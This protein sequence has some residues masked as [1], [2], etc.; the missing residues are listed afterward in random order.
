MLDQDPETS[1]A[2]AA[3]MHAPLKAAL[4]ASLART[5]LQIAALERMVRALKAE[6]AAQLS[7]FGPADLDRESE[8]PT[9]LS[10]LLAA[11]AP[12]PPAAVAPY[13]PVAPGVW[14]GIDPEAGGATVAATLR[15]A[16]VALP[17]AGMARVARLSANPTFPLVE[18]PRWVTLETAVDVG[19]LATAR[20]LVVDLVACLEIGS[21]NRAEIPPHVSAT[22]RIERHDGTTEDFVD[23]RVPVSSMPMEHRVHVPPAQLAAMAPAEAAAATLIFV[24]PLFGVYTFHLDYLSV[25]AVTD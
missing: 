12:F 11:G 10:T 20:E 16:T 21:D 5:T 19:A 25:K 7:S 18:K 1:S 23:Y 14:F 8:V 4:P 13:A 15:A 6:T 9:G 22:L 3:P 24:L 2:L 17:N